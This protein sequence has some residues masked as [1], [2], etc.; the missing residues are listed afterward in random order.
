MTPAQMQQK[1]NDLRT[2]KSKIDA[3][4]SEMASSVDDAL[5]PIRENRSK[6]KHYWGEWKATNEFT[7]RE[8]WVG[9]KKGETRVRVILQ[10]RLGKDLA[11]A[12][13]DALE[14]APKAI[15][16]IDELIGDLLDA[17][18]RLQK[19]RASL[20]GVQIPSS[21]SNESQFSAI[22]TSLNNAKTNSNQA[23]DAARAILTSLPSRRK[24]INPLISAAIKVTKLVLE[25]LNKK[26]D[27]L[28]DRKITL[29]PVF[30]KLRLKLIDSLQKVIKPYYEMAKKIVK[31]ANDFV[32]SAPAREQSIKSKQTTI[33]SGISS[34]Q[35]GLSLAP[36]GSSN[37]AG[38]GPGDVALH[39]LAIGAVAAG[40]CAFDYHERRA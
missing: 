33:N 24:K 32:D 38:A 39:L 13:L 9:E 8:R 6:L 20:V 28:E 29:T 19:A 40:I 1:L 26:E 2:R 12:Y 10:A 22:K 23:I 25:S 14:A 17:N 37:R 35:S 27:K 3:D 15:K 31:E 18:D 21:V 36:G 7:T 16:N 34:I 5:K 30:K 4:I 11:E